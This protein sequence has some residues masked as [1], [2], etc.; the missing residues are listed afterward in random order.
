MFYFSV[1]RHVTCTS[2]CVVCVESE[3]GQ[4]C[5]VVKSPLAALGHVH[6]PHTHIFFGSFMSL[7]NLFLSSH[8]TH[9]MLIKMQFFSGTLLLHL[10][11]HAFRIHLKHL[12]KLSCI[13]N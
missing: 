9:F 6:A 2:V 11:S 10:S 4:S 12:T 8:V 3:C 1:H 13:K 7:P 5:P